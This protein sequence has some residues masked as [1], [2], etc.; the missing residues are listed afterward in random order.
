[1][2]RP[3]S[4]P[5]TDMYAHPRCEIIP[6]P[7][8]QA[9]FLVDGREVTRWHFHHDAPRPFFHP[10]RGPKSG[11][12]LTRMGHPGAPDHDHHLS[13]WFAHHKVLG[14]D[15]WGIAATST[16]RQRNWLVYDDGDDAARMAVLLD[17]LDGHDPQPLLEQELIAVLRPLEGGEYTLDLQST[18]TPRAEQI[19]FQQ[20][21][22]GFLAVRVAKSIS[23]GFGGGAIT[24]S[25][26]LVGEQAIFGTAAEWMD[27]SGP[28]PLAGEERA[29]VTEGVTYFDHPSNPTFPAKWHVREDG[30]M[31]ASACR[32]APLTARRDA[33]LRLR[34]LLHV[35][36]GP[37][38]AARAAAVA[39]EWKSRPRLEAVKSKQPHRQYELREAGSEPRP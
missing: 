5:T 17:W 21:N 16:V 6:E 29:S 18:F 8:Q 33:P 31:G 23:G 35:H 9:A 34:Y 12:S 27:Y 15:F 25:T 28:M 7:Q 1:M 30:W 20:T 38:D 24:S 19:E 37:V 39:A 36:S 2:L 22:F 13:V 10:L 3:L 4:N 14:I 26:G 11:R 32:D